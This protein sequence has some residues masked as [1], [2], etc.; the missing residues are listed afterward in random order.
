[1]NLTSENSVRKTPRIE[2]HLASWLAY[3]GQLEERTLEDL[4]HEALL[5]Y[6]H[7]RR[8]DYPYGPT[9]P[10]TELEQAATAPAPAPQYGGSSGR[11]R[12][13]AARS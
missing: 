8:G 6:Y 4:L 10:E 3:V 2:R 1:M 7:E 11:S 13:A 5:R 9:V 12:K